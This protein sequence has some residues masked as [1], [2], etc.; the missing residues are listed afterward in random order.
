MRARLPGTGEDFD[1]LIRE[2]NRRRR[3]ENTRKH[4]MVGIPH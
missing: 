3:D 1:G 4:N 2:K